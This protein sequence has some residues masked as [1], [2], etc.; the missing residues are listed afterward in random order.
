MENWRDQLLTALAR[1]G[2]EPYAPWPEDNEKPYYTDK[3]DWDAFGAML[4]GQHFHEEI[5]SLAAKACQ[6]PIKAVQGKMGTS[7]QDPP[8]PHP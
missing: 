5:Q 3:P 8:P 2:Q 1:P 6:R 4:L 7:E